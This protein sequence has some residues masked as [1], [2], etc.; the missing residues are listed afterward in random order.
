M[1]SSHQLELVEQICQDVVVLDRVGTVIAGELER[2]RAAAGRR[3]LSVGLD[4]EGRWSPSIGGARV[5]AAEPGAMRLD[6]TGEADLD[7]L[8]ALARSAGGVTRFSLE[9]PALSDL[10]REAVER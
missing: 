3:R 5:L 8:V 1:V 7:R 4:G 6:L 2:L 9:P 10:F